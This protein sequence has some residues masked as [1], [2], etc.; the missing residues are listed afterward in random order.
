MR[1]QFA[2]W[3]AAA[4]VAVTAD[5][6]AL[7]RYLTGLLGP[8]TISVGA[9]VGWRLPASR[10]ERG[11]QADRAGQRQHHHARHPHR[12]RRVEGG[13]RWACR[14]SCWRRAAGWWAS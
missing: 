2:V 3:D 12:V 11:H 6:S 7:G 9:V 8:P 10:L 4:V 13:W 5:H 1:A 14:R